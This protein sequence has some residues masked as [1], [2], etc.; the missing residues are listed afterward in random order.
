MS[1]GKPTI[2]CI[3]SY[4]KGKTFLQEAADLGCQVLLLT[5]EKLKNATWPH[6]ALLD[7]MLMPEGL[8]PEQVLNTVT[9]RAR[10]QRID[11]VVALDEFDLE[12]AALIREHMRLPGMGQTTTRFFR[13]KLAMRQR[14]QRA[15]I[16]VPEF[17]P[18]LHYDDLREFMAS[19]PGPW[20]LKPRSNASAI[21]IRKIQM[22][23]HL[24]PVLDELGDQQSHYLLERFVPGDVYHVD[25]VTWQQQVL[26]SAVHEYGA[27]PMKVMHEGGVFTTRAIHRDSLD[28]RLLRELHEELVPALGMVSG[29]THTEFIKSDEDGE[30]YFL[31]S[32]ARVGGAYIADVVRH[33]TGVDLWREWARIEVASMRGQQYELPRHMKSTYAGSVLCLAKMA[34]PDLSDFDAPEVVEKLRRHHHAG[35]ILES[36]SAER[37]NQLLR[38]YAAEFLERFCATAPVPDRPTA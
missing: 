24:W 25:G 15:G 10:H 27:P 36:E 28:A 29:V 13:D 22:A 7:V 16:L 6:E 38:E 23:Q 31:E 34:E 8:S 20:V 17:T 32:A 11:R 2:L 35:M 14:A 21:G 37:L 19:V 1:D 18:V 33:A 12:A 26:M 30:F 5:V 3:S 4:E 9:Y